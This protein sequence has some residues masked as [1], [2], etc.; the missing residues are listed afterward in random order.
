MDTINLNQNVAD[1][2]KEVGKIGYNEYHNICTGSV[3]NVGW[4]LGDYAFYSLVVIMF[5]I[6]FFAM[7]PIY[8]MNKDF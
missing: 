7:Y 1:C 5:V 6:M 8:K 3:T 2:I 4:G